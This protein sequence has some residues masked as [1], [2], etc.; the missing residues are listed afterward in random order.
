MKYY[1]SLLAL[2]DNLI[3]LSLLEQLNDKVN[4]LGT[5]HTKNIASLIG[6]ENKFN[7]QVVFDDIPAFYDIKKQGVLKAIFD[8]FKFIKY[9]KTN[10][11]EEIMLEKK[12]FRSSFISLL[13]NTKISYPNSLNSKVYENRKE[14]IE[15]V[16]KQS[17]NVNSYRLKIENPKKILINPL[18]RV[19]LRNIKRNHLDFIINKL[20]KYGY[21]IYLIDIESRY[22]EFDNKVQYYL[23]NTT[24]ED[25]KQLIK[26]CDLYIGGD[27]FLIHLAYYLQRNYFMIFYRDNNDFLPPNIT[28]DFYIKAHDSGDFD[29]ELK[30]KF[31]NIELIK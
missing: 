18:T 20:N 21:E 5:K 29:D 13:T 16:Y 27:S 6:V 24:L 25:V 31:T 8:F 30:Q 7:I 17:I 22:Q 19:E 14:L 28:Q 9:L 12:D 11:I 3:S 15:N 4:I 2:G 10:N 1:V 23:T 26:E